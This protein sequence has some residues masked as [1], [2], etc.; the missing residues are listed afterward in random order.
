MRCLNSG[1][2]IRST[3]LSPDSRSS[4]FRKLSLIRRD[5]LKLELILWDC[6]YA[7]SFFVVKL[8]QKKYLVGLGSSWCALVALRSCQCYFAHSQFSGPD[9]ECGEN[10]SVFMHCGECKKQFHQVSKENE[11]V[12]CLQS[13]GNKITLK[14]GLYSADSPSCPSRPRSYK[15]VRYIPLLSFANCNTLY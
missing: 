12:P 15:L 10:Q 3:H 14:T 4:L 2:S 11:T 7:K 13:V 6:Q 5:I 8:E 1:F 9:I